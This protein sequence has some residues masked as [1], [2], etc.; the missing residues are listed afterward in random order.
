MPGMT[1]VEFLRRAKALYPHTVRIVLSGYTELQSIT[2]AINEGAIYKFLT[3][4]WEDDLLRANIEEAFRQKELADENRRLDQE[5]RSANVELAELNARLQG[6]LARQSEQ[7]SLA[8]DRGRTALEVLY[9]VPMPLIGLDAEGMV[10]FANQDAERL[11][12]GVLGWL[13]AYAEECLPPDFQRVLTLEDGQAIDVVIDGLACR[14]SCRLIDDD[15]GRRGRLV[16]I[17]PQR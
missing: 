7:M 17:V 15:G 14:C 16:A 1:G 4:P 9:N 12:P 11:L 13:G 5:V 8:E 3:K 2:A 6:A 10:A